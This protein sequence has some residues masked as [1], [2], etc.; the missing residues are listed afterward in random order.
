MDEETRMEEVAAIKGMP[1]RRNMHIKLKQAVP[2]GYPTEK[3][4]SQLAAVGLN[5]EE[6]SEERLKQYKEEVL[7][8]FPEGNR[9]TFYIAKGTPKRSQV[10]SCMAGTD[11]KKMNDVS[12]CNAALCSRRKKHFN[13]DSIN[14]ITAL[15]FC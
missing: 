4:K 14:T 12:Y 6:T 11:G 3:M 10:Y 2:S 13:F 15:S 9:Q 7:R 1:V 8:D 5:C